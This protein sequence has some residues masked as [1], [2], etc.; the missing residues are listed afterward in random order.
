MERQRLVVTL[1]IGWNILWLLPVLGLAAAAWFV[2]GRHT[3]YT[4]QFTE[5][6]F[7][8]I[9]PGTTE[10]E[11]RMLVGAPFFETPALW[12]YRKY[13]RPNLTAAELGSL[14]FRSDDSRFL[15]YSRPGPLH[16]AYELRVVEVSGDRVEQIFAHDQWD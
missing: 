3:L 4:S 7:S 5:N 9:A 15:W 12:P 10:N 2:A 8:Q 6:G 1:A 16:F 13:G 14:V 11:V